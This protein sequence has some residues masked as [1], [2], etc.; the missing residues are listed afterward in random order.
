MLL[1]ASV[2]AVSGQ[3]PALP[4][5]PQP[6]GIVEGDVIDVDNNLVPNAIAVLTDNSKVAEKIEAKADSAGHF[7]IKGVTPGTWTLRVFAPDLRPF[8]DGKVVMKPG[9]RVIEQGIVLAVASA[10]ADV[11]VSM[12]VEQ[13]AEQEMHDEE[14]QRVLAIF[15][16]FN[17]SYVW[18]AAPLN[19]RQKFH[20]SL[21]AVTDPAAFLTAGIVAGIEQG[22][23]TFPEYGGDAAGFGKRYGAA[24]G[25]AFIGR[26]LG[27]AVFPAI[28]RQDPRYFYMGPGSSN[29]DRAVH[30][31]A[32]GLFCRGNS[33]H[34]QV[35]Y[36]HLLGNFSAGVISRTYH[37]DST[38]A[39]GRPR[40]TP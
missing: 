28:F 5:A 17:T 26:M 30:A 15:P 20:L 33:G 19:A 36:S 25:D 12:T 34:T 18:N 1:L 38:N 11:T 2:A 37:P 40:A 14:K 27:Y 10:H 9:D 13:I 22:N 35:N 23:N 39:W 32:S 7:E 29:K 6:H 31:I 8:E 24:Y 21:K 3:T 4:S 16:N